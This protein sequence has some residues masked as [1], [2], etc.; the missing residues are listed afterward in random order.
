MTN[1]KQ[2]QLK[3]T[4]K[5]LCSNIL[6]CCK[7]GKKMF[8]TVLK[9]ERVICLFIFIFFRWKMRH[10]RCGLG[11]GIRTR[12]KLLEIRFTLLDSLRF[13][14]TLRLVENW[15]N[16]ESGNTCKYP[17]EFRVIKT[18]LHSYVVYISRDQKFEC[19][20]FFIL[21]PTIVLFEGNITK[22]LYMLH[23]IENPLFFLL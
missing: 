18:R 14:H 19:Y 2:F 17:N 20:L 15:E 12:T 3:H 1:W 7:R 23:L 16:S 5:K 6:L 21:L 4:F 22:M 13:A 10:M 8:L 9:I 11:T